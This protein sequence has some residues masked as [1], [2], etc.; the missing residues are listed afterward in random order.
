MMQELKR[1]FKLL[2]Y[3]YGLKAN[4]AGFILMLL[5]GA[6]FT[7]GAAGMGIIGYMISA[8]F[9]FLGLA[10]PAQLKDNFLFSNM[11]MASGRKRCLELY[12]TD[13]MVTVS[14]IVGYMLHAL[15]LIIFVDEGIR[16]NY[17]Q[18]TSMA[19]I[20]MLTGSSIAIFLV[21]YGFSNKCFGFALTVSFFTY[22]IL[23][24][25]CQTPYG[26]EMGSLVGHKTGYGFL[27]GGFIVVAGSLISMVLRRLLYKKP[28]S[29]HTGSIGLRKAMQ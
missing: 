28:V 22:L 5:L 25:I 14:G 23:D 26:E 27:V 9:L 11:V 10:M 19:T 8:L 3:A 17:L 18:G 7:V 16:Q 13:I 2:R 6:L 20:F 15:L 1:C 21:Y 4:I 12:L 29:V 24:I